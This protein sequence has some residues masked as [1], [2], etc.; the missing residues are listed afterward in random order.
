MTKML[1][2]RLNRII[3]ALPRC[4]TLADVGC[5]HGLVGIAALQKGV[6]QQV[7]F[8]DISLPSL[9]K[10][11]QNCPQQLQSRASFVCGNGLGNVQCDC[12]VIAGMGG[13][14]IVHILDGCALPDKLVLQPMRNSVQVRQ[15]LIRDYEITLDEKFFDGKY[16]DLITAQAKRGGSVLTPDEL[17]FGRT[18]LLRPSE[19]F[20]T[21]LRKELSL[22]DKILQDCNDQ[23]VLQRRRETARVLNMIQEE[24]L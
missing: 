24:K 13:L 12:A 23:A 10:A 6:A 16:Y 14:E 19:D 5:D 9:Q 15:R 1:S 4:E 11:K 18:N 17:T 7:I 22:C 8:T 3:A 2:L 21:F 20:V